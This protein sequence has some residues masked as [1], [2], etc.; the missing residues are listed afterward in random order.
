MSL[1]KF[2]CI[3][4][5]FKIKRHNITRV[6][7]WCGPLPPRTPSIATCDGMAANNIEVWCSLHCTRMSVICD[8]T[9]AHDRV[10]FSQYSPLSTSSIIDLVKSCQLVS[11]RTSSSC[12]VIGSPRKIFLS[13]CFSVLSLQISENTITS[14]SCRNT[15]F[16]HVRIHESGTHE[17]RE[18]WTGLPSA[19]SCLKSAGRKYC[20]PCNS[21]P[22]PAK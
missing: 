8:R 7:S 22:W 9:S 6:F 20:S 2:I 14:P 19:P 12:L 18:F 17:V 13:S 3:I 4:M 15:R 11:S 5:S 16:T 10:H 1:K 21:I